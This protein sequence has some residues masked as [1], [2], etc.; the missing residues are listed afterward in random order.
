MFS[1][2]FQHFS[3]QRSERAV[4]LGLV[5]TIA[6]YLLVILVAEPLRALGAVNADTV[7]QFVVT[8]S[9]TLDCSSTSSLGSAAGNGTSGSGAFATAYCIPSTNN[10][11]GYTLSWIIQT[12]SGAPAIHQNCN[13]TAPCYGT[14]HLLSNNMTG[15][16]PDSIQSMRLR[17]GGDT[18]WDTRPRLLTNA[19]VPSGSGSRWG[20]RLRDISTTPGGGSI[21]W[22]PDTDEQETYLHVNTGSTVNIAKRTSPTT[23][24]GDQQFLIFKVVIPSGAFQPTG[25]Y[26]AVIRF[27]ATDN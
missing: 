22:G 7:V 25:T 12:G 18:Y 11:L 23:G 3:R 17:V 10:S 9:L 8:G 21:N 13:S 4:S 5:A 6:L 2:I 16:Y 26:K 20:A 14:G 24:F 15:G 1:Y 19:T 27:T